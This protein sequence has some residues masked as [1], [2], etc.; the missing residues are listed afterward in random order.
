MKRASIASCGSRTS[1]RT[2]AGEQ[3]KGIDFAP[4][5]A[6]DHIGIGLGRKTLNHCLSCHTTWFRSVG[7]ARSSAQG[8]EG[9]DRGIGCER[10]HGPGLNHG[11]AAETGFPELAIAL[12]AKTPS[13][14]RLNSCVECHAADG[15]IQPSDPE[16]TRAQGTTFLFSRCYTAGKDRFGCTTCH[17]PH[18]ALDTV[19]SHYEVKCLSC[20]SRQ[21]GSRAARPGPASAAAAPLSQ[22]QDVS[23]QSQG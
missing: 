4:R 18:R 23:G 19:T 21:A 16:F 6:G 8:P 9:K 11:K 13:Q 7:P 1:A 2:R 17:D 3:T 22:G 10:C 5:D 15:S 20:H 14:E 12:S